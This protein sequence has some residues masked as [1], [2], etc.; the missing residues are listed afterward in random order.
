MNLKSF[1]NHKFLECT[2]LILFLVMPFTNVNHVCIYVIL[3]L[4]CL[5]GIVNYSHEKYGG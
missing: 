4:I 2:I 1:I 5:Y 3:E